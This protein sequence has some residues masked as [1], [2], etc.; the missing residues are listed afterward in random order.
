MKLLGRL[1][2]SVIGS[3]WLQWVLLIAGP[4]VVSGTVWL[5]NLASGS[6]FA[7][8]C[9]IPGVLVDAADQ[10]GLLAATAK[11][12]PF[13][14]ALHAPHSTCRSVPFSADLP[15]MVLSVTAGLAVSV[16][17]LFALRVLRLRG[18]LEETGLIPSRELERTTLRDVLLAVRPRTGPAVWVENTVLALLSLLGSAGMY[19]WLYTR[20]PIFRDLAGSYSHMGSTGVTTETLRANWWANH[21]THPQNTA[22]GVAVGA[23]GL[24]FALKQG[25]VFLR[26]T[27]LVLRLRRMDRPVEFVPRWLDRDYG[28]RPVGGL[29]TLG[30]L[31]ILI[32][33]ASFS[34]AMYALRGEKGGLSQGISILLA[35]I[36][37]IA[38][39]ANGLFLVALIASIRRVFADSVRLERRRI[40]AALRGVSVSTT[41]R[42]LRAVDRLSLLTEGSNLADVPNYPISGRWLRFLGLVPAF[43]GA[44]WTF[45]NEVSRAFGL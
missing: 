1:P 6:A 30:Y 5:C 28:W 42:R 12:I 20:G 16:Y 43:L 33:L 24:Y 34:A 14:D 39:V 31:A 26:V 40:L 38:A 45:S 36:A 22:L 35:L 8:G 25:N 37:V 18:E 23:I 41:R 2:E 13:V 3:R 17:L 15:N 10:T 44:L 27:T 4:V 21:T 32:F 19:F 9:A 29:V 11:L 7:P